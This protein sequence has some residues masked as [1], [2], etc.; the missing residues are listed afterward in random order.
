MTRW[1][2]DALDALEAQADAHVGARIRARRTLLGLSPAGLAHAAGVTPRQLGRY[3]RGA[4]PVPAGKLHRIGLALG[5]QPRHFFDGL[6]DG[7]DSSVTAAGL[8]S[9]GPT[10]RR[11]GAG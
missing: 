5:V 4:V 3:E 7:A 10:V 1:P 8:R 9:A 11:A 6:G 2:G